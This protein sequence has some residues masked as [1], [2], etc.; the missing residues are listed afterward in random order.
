MPR[1]WRGYSGTVSESALI[2]LAS[3]NEQERLDKA[4]RLY[5]LLS[6]VDGA[7]Q[8]TPPFATGR[9]SSENT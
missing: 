4:E 8:K 5:A 2:V 7:Q 9:R 1:R 3:K 6:N